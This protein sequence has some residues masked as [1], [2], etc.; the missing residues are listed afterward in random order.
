MMATVL[1]EQGLVS[2]RSTLPF[3][4]T[5][6]FLLIALERRGMAIH[7]RVD[8][9]VNARAVG[10]E[11][12]PTQLFIFGY[13]EAEGPILAGCPLMG[14]ELPRRIAVFADDAGKVWISYNDPL[15]LGRR[16][17]VGPN[18]WAL[19]QAMA[20]SLTGIVLE[21]GGMTAGSA[22]G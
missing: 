2:V 22:R 12:R 8:H 4:K 5:I 14:V 17:G 16:Y 6:A 9:A 15:W 7:A 21:A 18:V 3:A 19:L 20:T 11:L 1:P 10:L 13:P